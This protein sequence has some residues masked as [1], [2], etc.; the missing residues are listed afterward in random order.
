[1]KLFSTFSASRRPRRRR[2]TLVVQYVALAWNKWRGGE[3][4]KRL[5]QLSNYQDYIIIND[6]ET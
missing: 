4:V 1:M 2:L 3:K 6:R 5:T